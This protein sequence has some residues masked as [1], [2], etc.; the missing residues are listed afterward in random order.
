MTAIVTVTTLIVISQLFQKI[1]HIETFVSIQVANKV[2]RFSVHANH[3][4][5]IW[6]AQRIKQIT[7][8]DAPLSNHTVVSYFGSLLYN[9]GKSIPIPFALSVQFH[10]IL[11]TGIGKQILII[12]DKITY[13]I[14][15]ILIRH[16]RIVLTVYI[17]QIITGH[18]IV[19]RWIIDIIIQR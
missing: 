5:S 14:R 3:S 2:F 13:I 12:G 11:T 1:K 7:A 9:L 6:N 4:E 10:R 18:S 19:W 8:A 15:R 17:Q 16:I